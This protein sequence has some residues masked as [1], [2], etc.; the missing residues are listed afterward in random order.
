[1][2]EV[3]QVIEPA[4]GIGRRPS[5]KLGLHPRYPRPR[6]RSRVRCAARSAARLAALQP[7]SLLVTAAALPHVRGLS[8]LGVLRR[9]RPRP[10]PVGRQRA[11]PGPA[12]AA[13]DRAGG[14]VPVFTAI[15]STKEEP[16][17]APTASPRL[18]RRPSP[19][20]PAHIHMP[21]REFPAR[22]VRDGC[23][24]LPALIR[25]I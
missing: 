9:L 25:Q 3:E 7:P 2:H 10:G 21:V 11:R 12:L 19:C 23:A 22:T 20:L 4:A 5:V 6:P 13:R 8:R 18:R 14:T 16:S 15:R 24:P 1:V 17:F